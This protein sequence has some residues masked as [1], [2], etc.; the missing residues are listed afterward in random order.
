MPALAEFLKEFTESTG[1]YIGRLQYPERQ[2]KIDDDDK[3]HLDYEAPKVIK[4]IHASKDH[5]FMEGAVL[6]PTVGVTHDVFGE[7][8]S[9]LDQTTTS[10][11]PTSANEESKEELPP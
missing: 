11:D 5:E 3:A 6:P 1:V 9:R 8:Y 7:Q 2:I 4:F 10:I